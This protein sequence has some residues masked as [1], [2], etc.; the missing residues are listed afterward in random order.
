MVVVLSSN[1]N[2]NN[3]TSPFWF[4][5]KRHFVRITL[6]LILLTLACVIVLFQEQVLLSSFI[7]S[8]PN[9]NDNNKQKEIVLTVAAETN[10]EDS[11]IINSIDDCKRLSKEQKETLENIIGRDFFTNVIPRNFELKDEYKNPCWGDEVNKELRCLPYFYVLGHWQSG[12][13]DLIAR[14]VK[15]T[16]NL[17]T[18]HFHWWNEPRPANDYVQGYR[19]ASDAIRTS[20]ED[21]KSLIFGDDSPGTFA[22]SWSEST[23]LHLQFAETVKQCWLKCQEKPNDVPD[24]LKQTERRRCIDGDLEE[25]TKEPIGCGRQ[26]TMNDPPSEMGGHGMSVPHLMRMIYEI[27]GTETKCAAKKLK[28]IL[29]LREPAERLH[30]AFWHYDHYQKYFGASEDGFDKFALEM[31]NHFHACEQEHGSKGCARRFETYHPKF[32]AVFFHADQ[33]IKNMYSVWLER[34]LQVF[35]KEQFLFLRSEDVFGLPNPISA[36][37]LDYENNE[38]KRKRGIEEALRKIAKHLEIDEISEGLMEQMV[39]IPE[40]DDARVMKKGKNSPMRPES[41][42]LLNKFYE[43]FLSELS[44]TI[45]DES[46]MWNDFRFAAR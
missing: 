44:K 16:E 29:L 17:G 5:Q 41:R 21:T 15:H 37:A 39:E 3:N 38:R 18:R 32:E 27:G 40:T 11:N 25:Q 31:T 14:L 2:N 33:L 12:G 6:I 8:S 23:R 24:G 36:N 46:F 43:P 7:Y 26:A 35:S 19:F 9:N 28:F 13:Q 4:N 1:N 10:V 42:N 20:E 45:G 22:N 30:D 34:W